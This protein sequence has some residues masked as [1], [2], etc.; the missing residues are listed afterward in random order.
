MKKKNILIVEDDTSLSQALSEF[1]SSDFNIQLASNGQEGL[2]SFNA[3]EPDVIILDLLMPKMDG[4]EFLKKIRE[5]ESGEN[6]PIVILTNY[7]MSDPKT[8]EAVI[9]YKPTHF[10]V[11]SSLKLKE[12]LVYL[13]EAFYK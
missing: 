6:I 13:K 12:L 2:A 3:N 10:F 5:L 8:A 7:S 4:Y 9:T 11:K 1:L